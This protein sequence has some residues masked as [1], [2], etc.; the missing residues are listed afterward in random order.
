MVMV[1]SHHELRHRTKYVFPRVKGWP[2]RLQDCR[3][4]ILS[5]HILF[6][7]ESSSPIAETTVQHPSRMTNGQ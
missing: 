5:R 3:Q 1:I 2:Q 4:I 7:K 6:L